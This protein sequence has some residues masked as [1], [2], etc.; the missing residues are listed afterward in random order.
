MSNYTAASCCICS[1]SESPLLALGQVELNKIKVYKNCYFQFYTQNNNFG[2]D[3][4]QVEERG[5]ICCERCRRIISQIYALNKIVEEVTTQIKDLVRLCH[6]AGD[7]DGMN[8]IWTK[9]SVTR[10]IIN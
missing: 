8:F 5:R 1:N 9:F 4:V 2:K 10:L 3:L 6:P 7:G